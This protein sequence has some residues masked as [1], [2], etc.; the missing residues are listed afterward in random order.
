VL[1]YSDRNDGVDEKKGSAVTTYVVLGHGGFN[2][3]GSQYPAEV[4]VPPDTVLKFYSEAGSALVLPAKRRGGEVDSDYAKVAPAW[5]QVKEVES[6]LGATKPTYNYALYPDDNAEEREA[7]KAAD[8]GGAELIMIESGKTWLCM[9]TPDTCPTPALL[10]STDE[11][12]L[13]ED[14]WKHHCEGILGKHGGG[15]NEIHWIACASFEIAEPELPSLV[16][17][18]TSGPGHNNPDTWV[19]DD[20]AV[21]RVQKQNQENVKDTDNKD[22]IALVAGGALVLIGGDHDAKAAAYVRRQADVE[23]GIMTVK[24][25][26]A[27][28]KGSIEVKGVSANRVLVEKVIG[29]FSDKK[30]TF[31]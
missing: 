1:A 16:T 27:F 24:K 9:G 13:T 6:A 25:G 7:A 18:D 19:P 2:Q 15:S 5:Q 21:N 20:A 10:T 23:E 29:E 22:Q 3:E 8:W 12:V 11:A 4:L 14:R 30:V 17:A 26:G 28:S 31:V